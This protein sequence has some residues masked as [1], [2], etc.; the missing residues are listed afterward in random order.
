MPREDMILPPH[1][2]NRLLQKKIYVYRK[3]ILKYVL[4]KKL[5]RGLED[6]KFR[7]YPVK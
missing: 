3:T 5:L 6:V 7:K 2:K 1:D 4:E